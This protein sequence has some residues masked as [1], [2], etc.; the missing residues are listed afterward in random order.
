ML[1]KILYGLLVYVI[2]H[3]VVVA[4]VSIYNN[5]TDQESFLRAIVASILYLAAI[6]CVTN[7]RNT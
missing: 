5:D 6:I 1:K 2:G 7:N 4:S 3:I